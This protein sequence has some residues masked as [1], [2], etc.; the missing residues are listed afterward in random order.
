LK[1]ILE[2]DLN[3]PYERDAHKRAVNA[4]A[5]A[6]ALFEIRNNMWR[7][8]KHSE[9]EPTLSEINE[10]IAEIFSNCGINEELL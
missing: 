1:A 9:T 5:M 6:A 2:F 10:A 7:K 3:D 8:W 4:D